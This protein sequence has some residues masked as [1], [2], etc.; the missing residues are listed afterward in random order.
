MSLPND[1]WSSILN[2]HHGIERWYLLKDLTRFLLAEMA[3]N[4]ASEQPPAPSPPPPPTP[5]PP[6]KTKKPRAIAKSQSIPT[7]SSTAHDAVPLHGRKAAF[8]S[9]NALAKMFA[10]RPRTTTAEDQTVV[11]ED[12][13]CTHGESARVQVNTVAQQQQQQ[14]EQPTATQSQKDVRVIM[15]TRRLVE[16]INLWK[17]LLL[18][19]LVAYRSSPKPDLY[20]NAVMLTDPSRCLKHHPRFSQVVLLEPKRS[21]QS[22]T[23]AAV[24]AQSLV[25]VCLHCGRSVARHPTSFVYPKNWLPFM[26]NKQCVIPTYQDNCVQ[27]I[28]MKCSGLNLERRSILKVLESVHFTSLS[29]CISSKEPHKN[30]SDMFL[31]AEITQLKEKLNRFCQKHD[32]IKYALYLK[33]RDN[34]NL[35]QIIDPQHS[36]GPDSLQAKFWKEVGYRPVFVDISKIHFSHLQEY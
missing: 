29:H 34:V 35:Y 26:K 27:G 15:T 31:R 16:I 13:G 8:E 4:P 17:A 9:R 6:P 33:Y 32:P 36:R 19:D 20:K 2:T 21:E 24:F 23:F 11:L 7:A 10:P 5:P 3:A 14:Q 30:T 1:V 12:M 28:C 25:K 22:L 18:R